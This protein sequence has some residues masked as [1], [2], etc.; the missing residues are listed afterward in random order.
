MFSL[1][2]LS[3]AA[4]LVHAH[5]PSS[6]QIHWPLLS[7]R[8]GAEVWVKHENHLSTGAFKVRGGVVLLAASRR[9]AA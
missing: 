4:D 1:P 3:R 8:S 7:R 9:D 5:L 2:E 6:A